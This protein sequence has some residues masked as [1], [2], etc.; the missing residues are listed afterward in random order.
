MM[1]CKTMLPVTYEQAANWMYHH[2][3]IMD[4]YGNFIDIFDYSADH[5]IFDSEDIEDV[6]DLMSFEDLAFPGDNFDSEDPDNTGNSE[7]SGDIVDNSDKTS[8]ESSS[9]G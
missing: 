5:D 3:Y 2:G 6:D 4:T 7:M 1:T 9:K 8:K